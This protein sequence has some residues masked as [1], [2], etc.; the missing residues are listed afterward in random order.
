MAAL[1]FVVELTRNLIRLDTTNPPGE[2]HIAV[3]LIERLLHDAH[4]ECARYE[5]EPGRPNLVARVKGRGKAPP[6]LLQGHVDVVT[7]VNQSWRHKPFGGEIVDGY[8][9]GRGALDMKGGVAMMVSAVLQAHGRGGA[10]G[11]LVLA[12]LADEEAG[13]NQG[14]KWLVDNH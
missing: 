4:V 8:L 1:P 9:W 12:I 11:D 3:E 2:E 10:P 13:G 6:M 5:S 14:A 7:T